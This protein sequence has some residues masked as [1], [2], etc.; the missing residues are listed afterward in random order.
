[1]PIYLH[2]VMINSQLS[3]REY[4]LSYSVVRFNLS[5]WYNTYI[6]GF[7]NFFVIQTPLE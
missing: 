5:G 4:S 6:D 1:M 7:P 2:S 3:E